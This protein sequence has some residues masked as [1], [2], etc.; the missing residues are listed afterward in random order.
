[1]RITETTPRA[2]WATSHQ[3]LT[4]LVATAAISGR[5]VMTNSRNA[6]MPAMV[7]PGLLLLPSRM[8]TI[9]NPSP[10]KRTVNAETAT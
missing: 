10:T 2:E 4:H 8:W 7:A 9:A 1:V 6:R 5:A 3:R